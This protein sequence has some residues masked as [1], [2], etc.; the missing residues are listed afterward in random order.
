MGEVEY[1][2]G[3][4]IPSVP[5]VVANG[6]ARLLPEELRNLRLRVDFLL[7]FLLIEDR[8]DPRF[9]IAGTHGG[10]A[11]QPRDAALG[12]AVGFVAVLAESRT[13]AAGFQGTIEAHARANIDTGRF[14]RVLLAAVVPW[15]S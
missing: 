1:C 12:R 6:L 8:L 10:I 3:A 15:V 11:C 5:K 13:G 7:Y 14:S 2:L 9:G 4:V